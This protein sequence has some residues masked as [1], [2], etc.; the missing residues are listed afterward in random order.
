MTKVNETDIEDAQRIEN[1]AEAMLQLIDLLFLD[2][3]RNKEI[4]S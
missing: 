1:N 3:D 4:P 2:Y